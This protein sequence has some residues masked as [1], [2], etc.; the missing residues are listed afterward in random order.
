MAYIHQKKYD[1]SLADVEK[2]V[3]RSYR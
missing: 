1:K 3:V 2:A